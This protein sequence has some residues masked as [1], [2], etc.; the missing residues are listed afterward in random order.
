MAVYKVIQDIEAEDKLLGPLTLKQFIYG[1]VSVACL[2]FCFLGIAKH[3]PYIIFIFLPIALLA[4]FFAFPWGKDQPTETWALAKVRFLFKPRR[5]IWDQSGQNDLVTVTAPKKVNVQYTDNLTQNE[6]RSRLKA[7]ADTIDSRGW[8]VKNINVNMYAQPSQLANIAGS[9][10]LVDPAS[11]PQAVPTIDVTAS[12]DI[13]DENASPVAQH[14]EQMIEASTQAHRQQIINNLKSSQVE[15]ATVAPPNNYWFLNQPSAPA[16]VT[17][18]Y[19]TFQQAQVVS[20]GMNEEDLPVQSQSAT[21]DEEALAKQIQQKK[22]QS[23]TSYSH[24]KTI[25]PPGSKPLPAAPPV[26]AAPAMTQVTDTVILDLATNN[27][28]S[29]DS[30]AREANKNHGQVPPNDE[31]VISLH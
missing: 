11:L 27:D 28:R 17:P 29:V 13:M 30:L 3:F 12:D 25:L 16:M 23:N 4:G 15:Q 8:A 24:L 2:Y 5:R 18:G 19:T 9:D 7:L 20:P 6:V 14:F 31:V 22:A 26:Q 10:R 1:G 21:D